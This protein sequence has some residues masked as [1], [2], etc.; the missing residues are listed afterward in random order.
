M[1]LKIINTK[2]GDNIKMEVN[3]EIYELPFTSRKILKKELSSYKKKKNIKPFTF[4]SEFYLNFLPS[5]IQSEDI[6]PY[7][8]ITLDVLCEKYGEEEGK[9]KWVQYISK[10][11]KIHTLEG[12]IEKYGKEKGSFLYN[13]RS[14][15][16]KENS[17]GCL[18][19]WLKLGYTEKEAKEE[20]KKQRAK[21]KTLEWFKDEYGETSGEAE[22]LKYKCSHSKKT[23]ENSV[24]SYLYWLNRGYTE[25]EAKE[26]VL[27]HVGKSVVAYGKASKQSIDVLEP[28][29]NFSIKQNIN[30][31][32][33]FWGVGDS[34][35]YFIRD[36]DNF[37]RYDFTIK[38][39]RLIIE[40]NGLHVHPSKEFLTENEWNGWR[41]PFDKRTADEKYSY[42]RQKIKLAEEKGFK[43]Y[44]IWSCESPSQIRNKISTIKNIISIRQGEINESIK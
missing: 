30:K 37:Y 15:K 41:H 10:Q 7:T 38:P 14:K 36:N 11:K 1:P 22:F 43:V 4:C 29:Y 2:R 5:H 16:H 3:G 32:S 39:L 27:E 8:G 31:N 44:E 26:K 40:F 19:Y 42:D 6:K 18:E 12:K 28:I 20:V 9:R 23:K 21:G 13:E 35:E 33:I 34:T 25:N 17:V 24:G